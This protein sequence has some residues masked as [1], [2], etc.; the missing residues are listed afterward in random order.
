M[1][2]SYYGVY[3]PN[4]QLSESQIRLFELRGQHYVELQDCWLDSLKL[5]LMLW[6]GEFED[7]QDTWLRWYTY[8]TDSDQP[9]EALILFTGDEKAKQERQR[10]EQERQRAEQERQRAEQEHQQAEQ[11]RQRVEKLE[12]FLRSQG[13]DPHQIP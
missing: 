8:Q 6:Q 3:D 9:Q 13:L 2:V 1:R 10:A 7:R 12:E 5:G 4:Q 11:A